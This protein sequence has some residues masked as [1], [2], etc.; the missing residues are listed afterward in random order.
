MIRRSMSCWWNRSLLRLSSSAPKASDRR[1]VA[2][3]TISARRQAL[4]SANA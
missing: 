2:V 4:S 1:A 3:T